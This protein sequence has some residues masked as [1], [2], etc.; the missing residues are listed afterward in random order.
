MEMQSLTGSPCP[1]A[2][3]VSIGLQLLSAHKASST[4][5]ARFTDQ[6]FD[7]QRGLSDLRYPCKSDD[8]EE[9][10][11]AM[12]NMV[13]VLTG[14]HVTSFTIVKCKEQAR[15]TYLQQEVQRFNDLPQGQENSKQICT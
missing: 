7:W 4:L 10:S 6:L 12:R 13:C 2:V 11:H 3:P 9:H 15:A 5:L 14:L 8:R 1:L